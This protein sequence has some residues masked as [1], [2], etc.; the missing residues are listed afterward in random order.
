LKL[1]EP[2][3]VGVLAEGEGRTGILIDVDEEAEGE[4][5]EAVDQRLPLGNIPYLVFYFG[6]R[7]G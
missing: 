6:S 4:V 2:S 3:Q 1:Q 7:V 5:A